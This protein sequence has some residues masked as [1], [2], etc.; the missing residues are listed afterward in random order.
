MPVDKMTAAFRRSLEVIRIF[1]EKK[2]KSYFL[3][4]KFS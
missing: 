2:V 4:I 3:A 1:W